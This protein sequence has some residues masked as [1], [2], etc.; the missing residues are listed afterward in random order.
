[1]S[2]GIINGYITKHHDNPDAIKAY[3]ADKTPEQVEKARSHWKTVDRLKR[4]KK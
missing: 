2:Q 4:K 1:M 3:L